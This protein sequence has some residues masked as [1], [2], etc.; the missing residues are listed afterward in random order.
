MRVL[1]AYDGSA[2]AQTASDLAASVPWPAG[3]TLRLV[4]VIDPY[5]LLVPA[6]WGGVAASPDMEVETI[7]TSTAETGLSEAAARLQATGRSIESA[8]LRGRPASA[9]VD[10]ATAFGADLVIVGSRGHG[11]IASL[12]LGSVSAETVDHA[13]CPVLVA[14]RPGIAR[15]LFATDG[16][17]SSRTA[18]ALL[19][20]WPI[21][22]DVPIH[23]IS[24]ADVVEPWYSG[25]APTMYRQ[26]LEAHA[27]DLDE[28]R[29]EHAQTAADCVGRLRAAGRHVESEVRTGDAAVEIVDTA[30]A[31]DTDLV[32][33]GSRGRTGLK[34]VLLG[35]VARNVLHGS[36][37][38]VLV[39]RE[40]VRS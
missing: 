19:A 33:L 2:G 10:D 35:S 23:V 39:V 37:A 20:Q 36:H 18:E 16:S 13:P 38:S 21:F 40:A 11:Q 31:W 9:I 4:S 22:A 28:S 5:Q 17:P 8:V 24:V 15:V 25:V 7:V 34:R 26:V 27:R 14:R 3:S 32:V 30:A 1:I 6:P 29:K 12:A